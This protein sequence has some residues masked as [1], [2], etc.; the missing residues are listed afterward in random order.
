M[1]IAVGCTGR[2]GRHF[3]RHVDFAVAEILGD[4]DGA[5]EVRERAANLGDHHVTGDEGEGGVSLIQG[6]GAN[7]EVDSSLGCHGVLLVR[8]S[9]CGPSHVIVVF[10]NSCIS[11]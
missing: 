3:D 9:A 2:N 7:R 6:P 10:H 4:L 5:L 8:R 11:Q 1:S